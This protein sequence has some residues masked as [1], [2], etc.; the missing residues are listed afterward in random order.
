[1]RKFNLVVFHSHLRCLQVTTQLS[2][3]QSEESRRVR[4]RFQCKVVL[5]IYFSL[6]Q[7]APWGI[8]R[9]G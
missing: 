5:L 3:E 9:T 2:E 6:Y 4:L 7:S 8:I 1:M